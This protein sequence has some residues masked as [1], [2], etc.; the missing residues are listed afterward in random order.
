MF[1]SKNEL[2][3]TVSIYFREHLQRTNNFPSLLLP[4]LPSPVSPAQ[5]SMS[6]G[7]GSAFLCP[8]RDVSEG[9]IRQ[10]K[11]GITVA[12]QGCIRFKLG[13]SVPG[14]LPALL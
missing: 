4:F 5:M 11:L 2:W 13:L 9:L 6:F 10:V 12:C 3:Y 7:A 1:S 14:I 8:A